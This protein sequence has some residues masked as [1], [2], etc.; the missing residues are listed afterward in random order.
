MNK[1]ISRELAMYRLSV[2]LLFLLF[3]VSVFGDSI[4]LK[5]GDFIRGRIISQ[6]NEKMTIKTDA[7]ILDV[8][9][10]D[11]KNFQY[12]SKILSSGFLLPE[13][14][15]VRFSSGLS[16]NTYSDI[17]TGITGE[18]NSLKT[19]YS[20]NADDFSF[21]RMKIEVPILFQGGI[22]L[23]SGSFGRE[24]SMFVRTGYS[25]ASSAN[26][27]RFTD[28]IL[29]YDYSISL[30]PLE[31]GFEISIARMQ[32]FNRN[33]DLIFGIGAGVYR[34]NLTFDFRGYSATY[35]LYKFPTSYS[36]M[37]IGGIASLSFHYRLDE[38]I[39]ILISGYYRL[40]KIPSLSGSITQS[41]ALKR[42]ETLYINNGT[43]GSAPVLPNGAS[44]AGLDLSGAGFTLGFQWS[45][46]E[47]RLTDIP[48]GFYR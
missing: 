37:G 29:Q 6:N 44:K 34:A 5:N 31:V 43:F 4:Y 20:A 42:D 2:F 47:K 13:K 30:I 9:K 17:N 21:K 1:L 38:N 32:L 27:I 25:Y 14:S 26:T 45:F 28:S 40:A 12:E 19:I 35:D 22:R 10:K 18:E 15:Y 36:G 41:D 16:F 8:K 39:G 24:L 23:F 33:L 46:G 7:G 48:R 11:I 3:S